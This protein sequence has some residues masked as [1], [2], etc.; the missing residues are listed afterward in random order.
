M[1]NLPIEARIKIQNELNDSL[2]K[3]NSEMDKSNSTPGEIILTHFS[4]EFIRLKTEQYER[5][6]QAKNAQAVLI[7]EYEKKIEQLKKQIR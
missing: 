3:M 1:E 4:V 6:E 5:V 2:R 7:D